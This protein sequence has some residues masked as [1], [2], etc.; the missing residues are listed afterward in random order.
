MVPLSSLNSAFME[1]FQTIVDISSEEQTMV[2][3]RQK[4]NN[5]KL[6]Y[7][8]LREIQFC[9]NEPLSISRVVFMY[10]FCSKGV[11]VPLS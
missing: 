4:M 2:F 1:P 11:V 8:T 9:I 6:G 10:T 5:N 7:L 3:K